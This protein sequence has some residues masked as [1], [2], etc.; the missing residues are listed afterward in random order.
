MLETRLLTMRIM[1]LLST[2]EE[3]L[4]LTNQLKLS[5]LQE[6]LRQKSILFILVECVLFTIQMTNIYYMN[7]SWIRQQWMYLRPPKSNWN[8]V[9]VGTG[10]ES[11]KRSTPFLPF[12]SHR[13]LQM[14]ISPNVGTRCSIQAWFS[15]LHVKRAPSERMLSWTQWSRNCGKEYFLLLPAHMKKVKLPS[16]KL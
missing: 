12:L 3:S 16:V 8:E 5:R 14:S 9:Q 13:D 10:V 6:F 4:M 2:F 11:R 15:G 7:I 1:I